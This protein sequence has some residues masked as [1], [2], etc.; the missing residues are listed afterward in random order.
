MKQEEA[1]WV[2]EEK[3]LAKA[4]EAFE[5]RVERRSWNNSPWRS[6]LLWRRKPLQTLLWLIAL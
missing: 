2:A 4:R 6:S 1:V 3:R 5:A